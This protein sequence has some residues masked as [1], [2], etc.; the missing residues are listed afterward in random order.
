LLQAPYVF[1]PNAYTANGDNLNDVWKAEHAFVKEFNLKIYN[2]W[3]QLLFETTDKNKPFN[4]N[5]TNQLIGND[6]YVYIIEYS[7]WKGEGNTL[8][9]NFTVLK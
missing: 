8:K 2:R 6:V 9:G 4:L 1:V 7:G 5:L 3:G